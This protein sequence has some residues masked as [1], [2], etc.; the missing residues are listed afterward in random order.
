M[1]RRCSF[2]VVRRVGGL[3]E[4]VHAGRS[5]SEVVRRVG[6][7]EVENPYEKEAIEVVRRVGGLEV[8]ADI[9]TR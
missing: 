9:A 4:A 1:C 6:G 8:K 3:E 2:F 7:L 5:F